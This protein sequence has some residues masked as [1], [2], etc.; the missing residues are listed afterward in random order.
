M[1]AFI[2]PSVLIT[3][4]SCWAVKMHKPQQLS[5]IVSYILFNHDSMQPHPATW[6]F[7]DLP[8]LFSTFKQDWVGTKKKGS[9]PL[10]QDRNQSDV[11]WWLEPEPKYDIGE[12]DISLF[13]SIAHGS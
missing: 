7:P 11:S 13:L 2:F 6:L 5:K 8:S 10:G 12:N 9:V 3:V 1:C 4:I